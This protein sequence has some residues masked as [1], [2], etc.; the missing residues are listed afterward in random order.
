MSTKPYD[1]H[2][3]EHEKDL[4]RIRNFR[5]MDDE[6][7]STV[8]SDNKEAMELVLRIIL[9]APTLIV[10]HAHTQ[11]SV[12]NLFGK[13]IVMDVFCEDSDGTVYNVEIQRA[14]QGAVPKRARYHS[15]MIDSRVL[16]PGKNYEKLPES[17]VI[18]ITES[19]YF[20]QEKPLYHVERVVAEAGLPFRDGQHIIYVNG[21]YKSDDML[22]KLIHDFWCA[23]TKNFYY[24]VLRD[25]VAYYKDNRE[26]RQSMCRELEKMRAESER[27]GEERG[28][29]IGEDKERRK[30]VSNLLKAGQSVEQIINLDYPEDLV[31]EIAAEAV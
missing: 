4:E 28:K 13:D 22:G 8:L 17:Y 10:E 31:R 2:R 6:F 27:K 25:S 1:E 26:G 19:D 23:D 20:K 24:E 5:L 14:D 16:E 30:A 15:S 21:Q 12:S 11:E 3:S 9:D 29:A 7:M 18:F